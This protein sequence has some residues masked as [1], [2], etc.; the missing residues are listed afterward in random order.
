MFTAFDH[1]MMQRALMLAEK[2]LYSTRPNPAVGCVIVKAGEV[3]GEGWH[4]YAGGPHAE[5]IALQAAG[6]K[7]KG[8]TVYLALEPCSH[9]GK[10]PPCVQ[11]L[12]AASVARVVVAHLDPNPRVNGTG[13]VALRAAGIEVEVGLM[14]EEAEAL[15][16]GFCFHMRH[17]RPYVRCKI[18]QSLDGRTAMKSG[19]SQWI[20]GPEARQDGQYLRARSGA[21]ITGIGTVLADD[22]LLTVRTKTWPQL[23]ESPIAPILRVVIDSQFRMPATAKLLSQPG[24]IWWV[25]T[26]ESREVRSQVSVMKLVGNQGQVDLLALVHRLGEQGIHDILIE[27]GPTLS[28][29]FCQQGLLDE[30]WLYQAPILLG[31]DAKPT[32][33]LPDM[34]SLAQKIVWQPV[35]TK[36]FGQDLRYILRRS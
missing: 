25:G 33:M 30:L 13:I 18:A 29:A 9:F 5:I 19:E 32:M 3:I 22:P 27:A 8:A 2:G 10:T 26:A 36:T 35:S 4:Q 16:R 28:G 17:G 21:I 24:P 11:A 6:E 7:A 20:T 15:N 23:P 1:T 14:A 31:S 34:T 12:I